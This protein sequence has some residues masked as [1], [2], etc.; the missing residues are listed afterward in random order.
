MKV[1]LLKKRINM[2]LLIKELRERHNLTQKEF[3]DKVGLSV[4]TIRKYEKGKCIPRTKNIIKIADAFGVSL[5]SLV[6]ENRRFK[7]NHIM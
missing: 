5:E 2:I 4:S 1:Y 7:S 3:A 6:K